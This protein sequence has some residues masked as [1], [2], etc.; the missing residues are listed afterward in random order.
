MTGTEETPLKP[1]RRDSMNRRRFLKNAGL[2]AFAATVPWTLSVTPDS[3]FHLFRGRR[4]T[5]G[6]SFSLLKLERVLP[7]YILPESNQFSTDRF[8]MQYALFNLYDI[9]FVQAGDFLFQRIPSGKQATF[10]FHLNRY[11]NVGL[12]GSGEKYSYILRGSAVCADNLF[13]TPATWECESKIARSF[14]ST[15]MPGTAF[16]W[17]GAYES[18]SIRVSTHGKS[19]VKNIALPD[20]TWK[21]GLISVVQKMAENVIETAEFSSLDEMDI[22]YARQAIARSADRPVK[23][24]EDHITFRVYDLVGDG[25]IPTV[26]WV[27]QHNRVVFIISGMEAWLLS[28]QA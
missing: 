27:D 11:A 20:L 4:L 1:E 10:R 8:K 16:S 3:L 6:E 25:I 21:W 5:P 13:A 7:G 28:N 19:V 2:A 24:G 17:T 12:T 15:P 22:V 14:R 9:A 26:Y 18:G 23:Y